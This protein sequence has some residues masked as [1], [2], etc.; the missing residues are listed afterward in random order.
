MSSTENKSMDSS[1]N[2][3][4]RTLLL[5][6]AI[7]A[8]ALAVGLPLR[9]RAFASST[10]KLGKITVKRGKD[11]N[12][13]TYTAPDLG[14]QVNSHIIEFKHELIIVDV[15]HL[16]PCAQEVAAYAK[17]L[18]KPISRIYISHFHPDHDLGS[19]AFYAPLFALP[20]VR[21]K[22]NKIGDRLA[23]EE[24]AK[25]PSQ[26][27]IIADHVRT[28][29]NDA[30]LGM[31][32]VEGVALEFRRVDHAESDAS[33]T[34]A[35]PSENTLIAQDLVYNH[36]HLFLG[37]KDL[38]GWIKAIQEYK[39]LPYERILPGHGL[40]GGRELYDE[41]IAYLQFASAQLATAKSGED[42]KQSLLNKYPTY[43]GTALLEHEQRFLFPKKA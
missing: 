10:T 28:I 4:R 15:Q 12:F 30:T 42:F 18:G 22:V 39:A 5:S 23:G 19:I 32:T 2:A 6:G 34:I 37:Q 26:P 20:D 31:Q 33:L 11:V 29:D 1:F 27:E 3:T 14:W 25:F 9:L 36:V 35:I 43:G 38:D 40:P 17:S 24:R 7:A 16:L 41:N 8:S 13:H 21:E